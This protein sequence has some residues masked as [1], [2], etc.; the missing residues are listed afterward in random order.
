M[1]WTTFFGGKNN[2]PVGRHGLG[3]TPVG[4][5]AEVANVG[6]NRYLVPRLRMLG[7]KNMQKKRKQKKEKCWAISFDGNNFPSR[8]IFCTFVLAIGFDEEDYR[9]PQ[10]AIQYS[11][12]MFAPFIFYKK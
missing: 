8:Q 6:P 10:L 1:N 5:D 12:P 3:L 4:P 9:E 11:K 7:P 2:T